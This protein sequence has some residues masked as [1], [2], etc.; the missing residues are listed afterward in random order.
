[1]D[2]KGQDNSGPRQT[3]SIDIE[4][5]ISP[6]VFNAKLRTTKHGPELVVKHAH[7]DDEYNKLLKEFGVY[8][9]LIQEAGFKEFIPD[10]IGCYTLEKSPELRHAT[11]VMKN[12]GTSLARL[13]GGVSIKDR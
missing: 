11:L 4:G 13:G 3:L 2:S 1:M 12:C 8:H 7:D 6:M 10:V 9:R 5:L